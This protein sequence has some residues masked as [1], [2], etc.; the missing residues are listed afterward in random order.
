[1]QVTRT[2]GRFVVTGARSCGSMPGADP[3]RPLKRRGSR[4]PC[5]WRA[6]ALR[7]FAG[8]ASRVADSGGATGAAPVASGS[9]A[10]AGAGVPSAGVTSIGASGSAFSDLPSTFTSQSYARRRG[11]VN[12]GAIECRSMAISRL[13][14]GTALS[15]FR[16]EKLNATLAAAARPAR[17]RD[18]ALAL[19]RDGCARRAPPSARCSSGCSATAGRA[20]ADRPPAAGWCWSCR[21]SARSRP[22]RRRPPTSRATAGSARAAHRARHGLPPRRA[23]GDDRG[24]ARRLLH[25]RMTETVLGSLDEADALFRHVAPRPL[26]EVDVLGARPRGHRGRERGARPRA[27]AGR[28]RLPA[29]RTSAALG[30]NPTD[31]ELTMFAQANSR[32]LPPQDLQR[33]LGR[34][35]RA[36]AAVAVP[37]DPRDGAGEP[38]RH[39]DRLLGQ[40]RR[41]GGRGGRRF[42]ADPASGVYGYAG[43]LTHTLMKVETHNHPTAISPFPGAA[44]GSGGEIRDEGATGRGAKPKAGLCGFSVSNL[45]LPGRACARGRGPRPAPTASPRRSRS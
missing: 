39:G 40:R 24:R 25:D 5:R 3:R 23:T 41:D 1:M 32:A 15:G 14:G 36:A 45:R 31:V 16:L 21:A 28:D 29:S 4:S 33:R 26:A 12:V 8:F 27:R 11:R 19:R 13:P 38:G 9:A 6:G 34:R 42:F 22:G 43:E 37:D 20:A 18:A 2:D 44:T 35:R 10:A 30:R 7:A 17:G